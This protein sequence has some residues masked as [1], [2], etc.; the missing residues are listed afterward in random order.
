MKN[1]LSTTRDIKKLITP[2]IESTNQALNNS[3]DI[4]EPDFVI[5]LEINYNMLLSFFENFQILNTKDVN[6]ILEIIDKNI[7][8]M[9]SII[10]NFFD[11]NMITII[12]PS[13]EIKEDLL[14]N[15]RKGI[16]DKT[17]KFYN[18]IYN[19]LNLQ[20]LWENYERNIKVI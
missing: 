16:I 13:N 9:T 8:E 17:I 19:C 7:F 2:I 18:S 4:S 3:T 1:F 20:N 11:N 6:D 15:F 10:E 5:L 12:Y 14:S